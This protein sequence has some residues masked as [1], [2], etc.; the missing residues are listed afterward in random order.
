ME[1]YY[2]LGQATYGIV[3]HVHCML[4]NLGYKYTHS[5]C[6]ILRA[7]PLKQQFHV[8]TSM[9]RHTYSV[10]LVLSLALYW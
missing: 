4:D 7:L 9:L 2:R 1:K 6:V 3:A 5:R 8:R 10:C